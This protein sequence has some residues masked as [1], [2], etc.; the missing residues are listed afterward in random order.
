MIPKP[1]SEE[2]KREAEKGI[3]QINGRPGTIC[4]H[5]RKIFILAEKEMVNSPIQSKILEECLIILV[6]AK[7]MNAKLIKYHKGDYEI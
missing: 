3:R 6:Y 5:I 1:V 7:R 4:D 2:N